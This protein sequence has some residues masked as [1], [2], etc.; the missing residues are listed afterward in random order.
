MKVARPIDYPRFFIGDTVWCDDCGRPAEQIGD[1][2][3]HIMGCAFR[4]RQEAI[5][6]WLR[7]EYMKQ[8]QAQAQERYNNA[9]KK[10]EGDDG[11]L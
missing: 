5:L 9:L 11:I 10:F 4:T 7:E 1:L 3:T 8:E 6:F 2:H